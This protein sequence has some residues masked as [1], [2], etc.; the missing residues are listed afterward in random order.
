LQEAID[1]AQAG[2]TILIQPGNYGI[3]VTAKKLVI[4]GAGHHPL[5]SNG[6]LKEKTD[7]FEL[8]LIRPSSDINDTGASGTVIKG[9]ECNKF[10]VQGGS[11]TTTYKVSNVE[12]SDCLGRIELSTASDI[13]IWNHIGEVIDKTGDPFFQ[14]WT[15]CDDVLIE[16]SYITGLQG[17]VYE[18]SI[19]VKNNVIYSAST[20][21]GVVFENNIFFKAQSYFLS[22]L[23]TFNNNLTFETVQDTLPFGNNFGSGNI[24]GTGQP[25]FTDV[26]ENL[27]PPWDFEWD[28]TLLPGSPAINAG[29]D[30][31]DI[32]FSGGQ[33]PFTDQTGEPP[34]PQIRQFFLQNSTVPQ[35]G[36]IPIQAIIEAKN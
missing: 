7:I 31:T 33:Y 34:I 8:K 23:C 4:I 16:N 13:H 17:F 25:L 29:T 1:S 27:I 3:G 6:E 14:S 36:S 32:G 12:I 21:V 11:L 2:D 18:Q 35:G 28:F 20:S 22:S 26:P 24:V 10:I 9:V 19:I 30:G 5:N 15:I